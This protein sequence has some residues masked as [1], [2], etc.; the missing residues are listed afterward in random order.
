M[1]TNRRKIAITGFVLVFVVSIALLMIVMI[2]L[3]GISRRIQT[4]SHQAS[5]AICTA[6][7][8]PPSDTFCLQTNEQNRLLL[9]SALER[10]YPIG[11]TNYS[12]F[13]PLLRSY[14]SVPSVTCWKPNTNYDENFFQGN[15]PP[16]EL[17]VPSKISESYDCTFSLSFSD[18]N[19]EL[20]IK[21]NHTTGALESYVVGRRDESGG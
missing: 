19:T 6:F 13:V 10:N 16:P 14:K 12:D 2:T 5:K 18:L 9:Q 8:F 3:N 20:Q 4:Y 17:C 11:K 7:D 1:N 15:C 21:I